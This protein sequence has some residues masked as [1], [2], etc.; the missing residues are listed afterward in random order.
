MRSR[1]SYEKN[2]IEKKKADIKIKRHLNISNCFRY[3]H[4][5][6]QQMQCFKVKGIGVP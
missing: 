4:K 3:R 5:A 6:D 1:M 2:V